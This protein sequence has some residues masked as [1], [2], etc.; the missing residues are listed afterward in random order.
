MP[1][2]SIKFTRLEE[3]DRSS[4]SVLCDFLINKL[5]GRIS[6]IRSQASEMDTSNKIF[7][8]NFALLILVNTSLISY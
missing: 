5:V 8:L 1:L 3:V 4:L 7:L 2:L 6:N